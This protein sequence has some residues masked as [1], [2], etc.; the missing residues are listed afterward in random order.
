M[1]MGHC[2]GGLSSGQRGRRGLEERGRTVDGTRQE[3][4][5]TLR[6]LGNGPLQGS[7]NSE[8]E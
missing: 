3:Q 6:P 7:S 5:G 2:V 8:G 4:A 1:G